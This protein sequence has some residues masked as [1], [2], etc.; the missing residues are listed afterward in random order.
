[1]NKEQTTDDRILEVKK[2]LKESKGKAVFITDYYMAIGLQAEIDKIDKKEWDAKTIGVK[3]DEDINAMEA[4]LKEELDKEQ[5]DKKP[6]Y[7]FILAFEKADKKQRDLN[8]KIT[9]MLKKLEIKY[10]S[11]PLELMRKEG[12]NKA[13][14][15]IIGMATADLGITEK[16]LNDIN[17]YKHAEAFLD[18]LVHCANAPAIKTGFDKFDKALGARLEGGKALRHRSYNELGK[19]YFC[20]TDSRQYGKE[21]TRRFNIQLGNEQ[22]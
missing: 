14:P 21:E 12:L 8:E 19:D 4:V 20:I 15:R 22:I 2:A 10:V 11:Y 6:K 16:S 1:M 3:P 7:P 5:A 9:E 13:I 18:D 17:A